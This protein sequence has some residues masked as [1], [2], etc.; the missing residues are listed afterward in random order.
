M[1]SDV[2]L[3]LSPELKEIAELRLEN[4]ELS[5]RALG[6]LTSDGISRSGVNH[7]LKKLMSYTDEV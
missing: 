6:E 5:L 7:R 3:T 4:P 2:Y 1:K